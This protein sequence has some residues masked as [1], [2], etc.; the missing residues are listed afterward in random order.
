M[1]SA[2]LKALLYTL[3][4][5][6]GLSSLTLFPCVSLIVPIPVRFSQTTYSVVEAEKSISITLVAAVNHTFPFS[7]YVSTR[8]GTARCE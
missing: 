2:T 5:K 1:K 8:D 3:C 4:V 7:V 6:H